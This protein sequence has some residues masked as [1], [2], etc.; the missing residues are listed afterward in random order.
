MTT[1]PSPT[2]EPDAH[3]PSDTPATDRLSANRPAADRASTPEVPTAPTTLEATT[4]RTMTGVRLG[5]GMVSIILGF[6]CYWLTSLFEGG[7]WRG[8]FQGATIALMVMGAY[9]IGA[10]LWRPRTPSSSGDETGHWLPSRDS[11]LPDQEQ[12]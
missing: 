12:R 6:G 2:P 5:G 9:L 7:F 3:S 10:G 4:R 1:S 11:R 8:F